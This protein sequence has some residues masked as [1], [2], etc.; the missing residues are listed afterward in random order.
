M[1]DLFYQ[2]L[3]VGELVARKKIS[4]EFT[5]EYQNFGIGLNKFSNFDPKNATTLSIKENRFNSSAI[6]RVDKKK[7]K[8]CDMK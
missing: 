2:E 5:Q 1:A 6:E 4:P 3:S 8:K 7:Q